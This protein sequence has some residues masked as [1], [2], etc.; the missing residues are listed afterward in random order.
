[1]QPKTLHIHWQ[2]LVENGQTCPR[3]GDTEKVLLETTK[4]LKQALRPLGVKV[5]LHT[6]QMNRQD[7]AR[8]PLQSNTIHI[9]HRPLEQWLDAA[10]GQS[11]CC[12]VCGP[13]DCRTLLV[14]GQEYEGIPSE[15][16]IRAAL[17][18]AASLFHPEVTLRKL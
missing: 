14:D 15:L 1:M 9:N 10:T 5:E 11:P 17:L 2:R 18:A 16:I 7:F 13:N 4:R 12:D 6:T 8:D 3:C